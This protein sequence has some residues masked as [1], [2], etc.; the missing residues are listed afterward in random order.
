ML[1]YRQLGDLGLIGD[2]L[3]LGALPRHADAAMSS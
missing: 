1:E 2:K 3:D